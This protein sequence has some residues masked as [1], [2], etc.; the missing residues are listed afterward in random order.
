MAR[1]ILDKI[2]SLIKNPFKSG[3]KPQSPR[4]PGGHPG[5][6]R[7]VLQGIDYG[8]ERRQQVDDA[9]I[10]LEGILSDD[11][12]VEL[13]ED[14]VPPELTDDFMNGKLMWVISSNVAAGRYIKD[15]AKLVVQFRNGATYSYFGISP[16]LAQSFA[17]ADSFGVWIWDNLRVRGTKY[18]HQVPYRQGP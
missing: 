6:L 3:K 16:A 8:I 1:S 11:D 9:S 17:D 13:L 14:K 2:R 15:Q 18:G 10:L 5:P 7:S 4:V 12:I